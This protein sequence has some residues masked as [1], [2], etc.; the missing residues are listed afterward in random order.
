MGLTWIDYE[1][2]DKPI[3]EITQGTGEADEIEFHIETL[4]NAKEAA[5]YYGGSNNLGKPSKKDSLGGIKVFLNIFRYRYI[6]T[7]SRLKLYKMKSQSRDQYSDLMPSM[8]AA[9]LHSLA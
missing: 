4:S 5:K 9:L 3:E 1:T 8:F 7:V 2:I 6:L